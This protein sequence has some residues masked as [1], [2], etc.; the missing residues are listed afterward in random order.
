MFV[1]GCVVT[2]WR[3]QKSDSQTKRMERKRQTEK[4]RRQEMNERLDEL[5]TVSLCCTNWLCV[6]GNSSRGV[7]QGLRSGARPRP[8]R[9]VT[10]AQPSLPVS[11]KPTPSQVLDKVEL[12]DAADTDTASMDKSKENHRVHLLSRAIR[13]LKRLRHAYDCR[14]AEVMKYALKMQH[15]GME[16]MSAPTQ[17]PTPVNSNAMAMQADGGV[18]GTSSIP[19]G[20]T[21]DAEGGANGT[22][23]Y[24]TMMVMV[25]IMVPKVRRRRKRRRRCCCLCTTHTRMCPVSAL[26][27][28]PSPSPR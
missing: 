17:A 9:L 24:V 21:R 23:E 7:E 27:R 20:V 3:G 14:T 12:P 13:S 6:Y 1:A 16:S 4:A 19:H 22:G 25:P 18:G 2:L 28:D 15:Q 11:M 10:T 8:C 5:A 26:P